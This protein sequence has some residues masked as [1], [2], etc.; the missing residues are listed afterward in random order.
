[1]KKGLLL[2]VALL[3]I[4]SVVSAQLPPQG[5][6]GLFLDEERMSWCIEGT[7][8]TM[9]YFFA[10]PPAEGLKCVELKLVIPAGFFIFAETYHADVK[11]P[12]MGT[13]PG[14]VAAC[15]NIC[16]MEGW[17]QVCSAMLMIGSDV[18]TE[19]PIVAMEGS[20]YPKILNCSD[21]A[22]EVE[23][24]PYNYLYTNTFPCP[25]IANSESTWGA[26]KN[27]YE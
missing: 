7:E 12:V 24:L 3:L 23:A 22:V 6:F 17:V 19:I 5:Y 10:L 21:P 18:P 15:F 2:G 16:Q 20:P 4:A 26:I 14:G 1:M 27:M 11:T 9:F 13:L 8:T 25:G